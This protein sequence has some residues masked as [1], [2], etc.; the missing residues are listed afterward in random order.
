MSDQPLNVVVWDENPSHAPVE[1]YPEN[2]RGAVAEGLLEADDLECLHVR[3][4]HLDEQD[5]GLP[6]GLLAETDVLLWWGHI[7]HDEVGDELA[8]RIVDRVKTHGLGFVALHSAHYAKPFRQL[9]GCTGHLRGG[10]REDDQHEEIHV[11]AP[12]HPIVHGVKD[13]TLAEEEMYGA[14]FDVPPPEVVVLQSYF[15]NEDICFPS[16]LL[17]T[18]GE[19]IKAEFESGPGGGVGQGSGIGRVFYFR[20]GHESVPTYFNPDVRKILYNAT[21]WAGKRA[22]EEA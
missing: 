2:I 18:V 5:Q 15:P 1:V 14:P 22:R 20:P 8:R 17:W 12:H 13:F 9:L 19:G 21:L 6:E 16:G 7:R 4:A 10:W 3:V 11:C